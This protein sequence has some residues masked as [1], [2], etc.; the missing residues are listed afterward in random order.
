MASIGTAEAGVQCDRSKR[1]TIQ[2][3]Y[4]RVMFRAKYAWPVVPVSLT[5]LH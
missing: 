2:Q 4:Q 5:T 3:K 1:H